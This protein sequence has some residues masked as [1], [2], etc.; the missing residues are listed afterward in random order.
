MGRGYP[1]PQQTRGLGERRKLPQRG[2]GRAPAKTSVGLLLSKR[3]RT[4]IVATFVENLR[5]S[6]P[7][8]D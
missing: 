4:P 5:R 6:E 7:T 8:A 1:P 3:V 2:L